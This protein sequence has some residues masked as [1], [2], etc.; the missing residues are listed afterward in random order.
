[1]VQ[2]K[3]E[4][5]Y[6]TVAVLWGKHLETTVQSLDEEEKMMNFNC[7][8]QPFTSNRYTTIAKNG[9]VLTSQPLAAG[10]G[11]DILKRG[12]NAVDA[13]IA[14]AACL[15]VVEP[16][17]NGIGSD[18]FAL[19]WMRSDEKLY[20]I[21]GS[22]RSPMGISIDKVRAA[23]HK[24]MPKLGWTPVTVSGAPGTWAALNKRFG[25][26]SLRECLEP[27]IRYAREGYPLS[28]TLGYNWRKAYER[29]SELLKGEEYREWFKTFTIEGRCPEVGEVIK[30]E[31]HA[32]TLESIGDTNGESFYRGEIAERIDETSKKYGGYIRK[33]DYEDFEPQ[34]VDPIRLN[35]RGYE[36]CEIPPNGQGIV[37]LMALNIIRGY[38]FSERSSV[39]TLH[40][41][42]EAMKLAFADGKKYITDPLEMKW[43]S[44]DLLREEYAEVRRDLITDRAAVPEPGTPPGGGTVY[45]CTAD[46]EGNMVSFIQSNYMGF[47]S[48]IVVDGTGIALQNR[49]GDFSLDPGV[50]NALKPGKRTYHT[51]IPGFLLKD[52][53]AVGPFGVMGGYMQPQGHVQVVMN[54]ID[55]GLN[56]QMALDA[57]RWRWVEGKRIEVESNFPIHLV[58]ALE[59]RGH[60]VEIS[61]TRSPFGRGQII[62]ERGG[63]Y[64]GGTE[65]RTDSC[66]ACY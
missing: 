25:K 33:E 46:R 6:L 62:V 37:A 57:P 44:E 8:Y 17:S 3:S 1:M 18:A 52:N 5:R 10:A 59:E 43:S 22:G 58:G 56:P 16:T 14:T 13:A 29:Y 61:T 12:G 65:S 11:L 2:H 60:E 20:G 47:G 27:A 42:L 39:D 26:L 36:I 45:L 49:G 50:S 51:I 28:P 40:K 38:E 53:K 63:V 4:I 19:V 55:F 7:N 15:T 23:G 54:L 48:G 9:M 64:Y 24:E 32:K 41:Q 35:Y 31:N 30:L 66:V 34:W 21:N